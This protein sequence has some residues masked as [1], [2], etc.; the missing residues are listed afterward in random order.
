MGVAKG[1][2]LK[3]V[4]ILNEIILIPEMFVLYLFCEGQTVLE[5]IFVGGKFT[6]E[7]KTIEFKT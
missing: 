3:G 4:Y 6:G 1:R 2:F 7:K 5:N